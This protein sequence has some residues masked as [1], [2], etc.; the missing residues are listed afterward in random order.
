MHFN[1]LKH[2]NASQNLHNI[3]SCWLG[4]TSASFLFC[5]CVEGWRWL[6]CSWVFSYICLSLWVIHS[7]QYQCPLSYAD[8]ISRHGNLYRHLLAW[9]QK[10]RCTD[11][12]N[13]REFYCSDWMAVNIAR[14]A[15]R[16]VCYFYSGQRIIAL[17][18]INGVIRWGHL[19]K[20][21]ISF[22]ECF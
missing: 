20:L 21:I 5:L 19:I 12:A 18:K 13:D 9:W 17:V 11:N 22:P 1:P 3:L 2:E 10:W 7:R 15:Q 4:H 8:T 6:W 14:S 16:L